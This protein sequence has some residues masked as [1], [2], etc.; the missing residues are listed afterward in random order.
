MS[1]HNTIYDYSHLKGKLFGSWEVLGFRKDVFGKVLCRCVCGQTRWLN[2]WILEKGASKSCGCSRKNARRNK[3]REKWIGTTIRGHII[4]DLIY[5]NGQANFYFRLKCASCGNE[6]ERSRGNACK[7]GDILACPHCRYG[8]KRIKENKQMTKEELVQLTFMKAGLDYS[9][10]E[11]D[12]MANKDPKPKEVE[13]IPTPVLP[14]VIEK[15]KDILKTLDQISFFIK[16]A[17]KHLAKRCIFDFAK[18]RKEGLII[19]NNKLKRINFDL[20]KTEK[21]LLEWELNR[22]MEIF[23]ELPIFIEDCIKAQLDKNKIR[24]AQSAMDKLTEIFYKKD[25]YE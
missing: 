1:I 15:P 21:P 16:S 10:E 19:W 11:L 13:K 14:P 8:D 3:S 24:A 18:N 4:T 20:G 2:I 23:N 12:K 7:K 25:K 17:E 5:K 9:K 6:F 22:R